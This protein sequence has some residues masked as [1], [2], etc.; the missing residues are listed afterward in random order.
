[1]YK[2]I[3]SIIKQIDTMW[4]YAGSL[5]YH[6]LDECKATRGCVSNVTNEVKENRF[7]K[8][9]C[10]P[11]YENDSVCISSK[12]SYKQCYLCLSCRKTFTDF[13]HSP[14]YNSKKYLNKWI[15][16]FKDIPNKQ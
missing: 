10:Y 1:M 14:S 6:I 8:G 15:T 7:S 12:Y 11:H 5:I 4:V 3:K 9:K 13:T 16:P 2:G